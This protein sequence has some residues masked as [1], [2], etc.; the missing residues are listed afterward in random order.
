MRV[1]I[2]FI[3]GVGVGTRGP[4]N[5]LSEEPWL[6]SQFQDGTG[7]P[8]PYGGVRHDLNTTFGVEG[9]PQSASN[10]TALLTGLDAPAII[11]RHVLGYPTTALKALIDQHGVAGYA[12]ARGLDVSFLNAF[13]E[14]YLQGL[15]LTEPVEGATPLPPR[16]RK[17]LKPSA[18]TLT[19]RGHARF[20]T[21]DDAQAGRALT[22][23]IS[24]ARARSH[25]F[26]VPTRTATE[27]AEIF[28]REAGAL[29]L[30]E[31]FLAD[32]AGH[33]QDA[34]AAQD[35]LSTFDAFAREV[36]ASR[37]ADVQVVIC[38]DHGNVEDLSVRQHTTHDVAALSF[39]PAA[40]NPLR[41]LADVGRATK[42]WLELTR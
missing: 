33:A 21:F 1:A 29:T 8:L 42:R 13:P 31:H 25:G 26:D 7:T 19:M 14:P 23:D 2:V 38:S 35:A 20:R 3:D 28:W 41:S 37:P 17:R 11:G 22:H 27:A 32:E 16:W 34:R 6:L 24:G 18:S 5:P 4:H 10:Q 12:S 36:L 9:R 39:G 40:E 15:G 30:F